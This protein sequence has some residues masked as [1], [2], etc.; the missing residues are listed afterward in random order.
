MKHTGPSLTS[1]RSSLGAFQRLSS[2]ELRARVTHAAPSL[3]RAA[4]TIALVRDEVGQ[5]CF[6]LT[7]R[8]SSLRSHGGQWALPGGRLEEGE[9][10]EQAALRETAEEVGLQ[11]GPD[12]I[13]GKLDDYISRSGFLITPIVLGSDRAERLIADPTEVA[14]IYRVPLDALDVEE[15]PILYSIEESDRPVLCLPLLGDRVHAPT[16]AVLYQFLEVCL[17]GQVEARVAHYEQ[18]VFAWR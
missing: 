11:L 13:L 10:P 17:R 3:R 9:S 18:P 5:L 14:R 8:A 12:A 6:V 1:I 7:R 15:A 4:V 16:A 2:E